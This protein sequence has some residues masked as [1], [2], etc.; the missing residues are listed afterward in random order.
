M[1]SGWWRR[2]VERARRRV[3]AREAHSRAILDAI[4]Q[5]LLIVDRSGTV[6]LA[7]AAFLLTFGHPPAQLEGRPITALLPEWDAFTPAPPRASRPDSRKV[8]PGEERLTALRHASGHLIPVAPAVHLLSDD[9]MLVSLQERASLLA[10]RRRQLLH[11]T[12]ALLADAGEYEET[13]RAV[14]ALATRLLADWVALDFSAPDGQLRRRVTARV[15]GTDLLVAQQERSPDLAASSAVF[16]T[17]W[18]GKARLYHPVPDQLLALWDQQGPSSAGGHPV[19]AIIVPLLLRGVPRG[20]LSL[21]T[22]E[23]PLDDADVQLAQT[24]AARVTGILETARLIASLREALAA[25]DE[26][27]AQLDAILRTAPVGLLCCNPD[28]TV[29]DLND[30]AAEMLALEGWPAGQGAGPLQGE[31]GA[32]IEAQALRVFHTGQAV[33]GLEVEA[34][35]RDEPRCYALSLYPIRRGE[36]VAQVGVVLLDKT[37]DRQAEETLRA[38]LQFEQLLAALSTQFIALPSER[39]DAAIEEALRSVAQFLDVDGALIA[40][41]ADDGTRGEVVSCWRADSS[42]PTE[43]TFSLEEFPWLTAQLRDLQPVAAA[44]LDEIGAAP[45]RE[46]LAAQ[47]VGSLLCVPLIT[48]EGAVGFLSVATLGRETT[49]TSLDLAFAR[50]AAMLVV[51]ALD[52]KRAEA[53]RRETER[54]TGIELAAREMAHLITNDITGAIG[55]LELLLKSPD[56]LD[57]YLPLLEGALRNLRRAA[58][59]VQQLQAVVRVATKETAVGPALDLSRSLA[60][61]EAKSG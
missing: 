32:I 24:F 58:E 46:R 5:P 15:A 13:V 48:R 6:R 52:R 25:R 28:L 8:P 18:A 26:R 42:P 57:R 14:A 41:F 38:R 55:G 50:L 30:V 11:E 19:S 1:T 59:H 60:K 43:R 39:I 56:R 47:N 51:S 44:C 12:D 36:R 49:W 31:L 35:G 37:A 33:S 53:V 10:S 22:L 29:A 40:L 45:E 54:L 17:M 16:E 27:L 61:E 34:P 2:V 21:A 9:L 20:A 7:N 4:A 3:S 23:R